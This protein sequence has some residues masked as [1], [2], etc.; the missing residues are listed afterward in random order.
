MGS[1]PYLCSEIFF[2]QTQ[3][4]CHLSLDTLQD[5]G[6][7]RNLPMY[8][9]KQNKLLLVAMSEEQQVETEV[10]DMAVSNSG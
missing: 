6:A 3:S 8:R 9:E 4:A 2:L 7:K 1:W 10:R 5:K